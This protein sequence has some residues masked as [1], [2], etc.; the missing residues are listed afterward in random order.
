MFAF[1]SELFS[2]KHGL[3]IAV[4]E[5]PAEGRWPSISSKNDVLHIEGALMHLGFNK[6]NI[7]SVYDERATQEG[8]IG[9]IKELSKR[10]KRGDIVYIHFS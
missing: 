2:E 4:G 10:V 6:A 8:I 3:I 5:Y 7:L 1:C 9:A